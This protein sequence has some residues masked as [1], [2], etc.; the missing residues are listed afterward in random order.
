MVSKRFVTER[1]RLLIDLISNMTNRNRRYVTSSLKMHR[2][3]TNRK[4]K[5]LEERIQ[6]LEKVIK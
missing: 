6:E 1:T 2:K 5:E 3:F 4:I